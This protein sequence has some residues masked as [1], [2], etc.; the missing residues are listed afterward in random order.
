MSK[1]TFLEG[2]AVALAASVGGSILL[3]ILGT[4]LSGVS[5]VRLLVAGIGLVYVLY[6][7]SRSRER[8]GRVTVIAVWSLAAGA[9]WFMAP[10][11][12]LYIMAHI[13][14]I[15]LI[16]SL[17]FYSSVLSALADLGLSGLGLAAAIW[18]MVNTGS[19]FLA[20]WCFFLTQALFVAIPARLSGRKTTP[21]TGTESDDR[22]Q[23]AYS[24]AEA[25]LRKLST[26]R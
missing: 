16:R 14:L 3:A 10:S 22:F 1:P 11:L 26:V 21:Q 18:A 25:A 5:V 19:V 9:L 2:V 23:R 7:L 20:I 12:I 6:L 13:G 4:A 15:W 17:Y 8:V 24:A